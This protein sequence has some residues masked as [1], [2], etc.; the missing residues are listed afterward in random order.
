MNLMYL[1]DTADFVLILLMLSAAG[2]L[3]IVS[4]VL[5]GSYLIALM[6]LLSPSSDPPVAT[7]VELLPGHTGDTATPLTPTS[8]V[9]LNRAL[10]AAHCSS[11]VER[12][13]SVRFVQVEGMPLMAEPAVACGSHASP[14]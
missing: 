2:L 13:V 11:R 7:G 12:G 5:S 9:R 1:A 3:V 6:V 10:W 4:F 8:Y 14:R